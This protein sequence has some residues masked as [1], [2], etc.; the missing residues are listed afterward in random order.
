[1]QPN[2]PEPVPFTFH[3]LSTDDPLLPEWLALYESAFPQGERFPVETMRTIL[4]NGEPPCVQML[5]VLDESGALVGLAVVELREQL[6]AMFLWYLAVTPAQR[7]QGLGSQIYRRL[8]AEFGA[9]CQALVFDVEI[10]ELAVDAVE[11]SLRARRIEFYRRHGARV[12]SGIDYAI[13]P[14]PDDPPVALHFMV[15]P[16][17]PL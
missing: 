7:S 5:A 11:R 12:L 14:S 4:R 3:P 1:M 2:I 17:Q 15:H 8:I 13:H 16:L 10:P 9:G 6:Q